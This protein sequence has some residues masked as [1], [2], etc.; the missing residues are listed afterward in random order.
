MSLPVA[1]YAFLP[2]LRRGLGADLSRVDG[3][4]GAEPRALLPI[5]V[6]FNENDAQSGGVQLAL[7][8]PGEVKALDARSVIRTW[9]RANVM[10]AEP[11]YFPLIEFDQ[12]DLPWRY[13]PARATS[14][15]RLT[16][17][18]V[19]IVLADDEIGGFSPPRGNDL[20]RVEIKDVSALP[21]W[22]QLWAWAHVQY[23][24]GTGLDAT[25]AEALLAAGSPL[26]TSRLLCARRLKP[27]T[28]YRALLVPAFQ[29]GLL[30]GLGQPVPDS[31]DAL[32]PAWTDDASSALT[33]P[34]YY[35]WRFGTGT[36]GDFESLARLLKPFEAPASVGIRDMDVSEPSPG[37]PAA[38]STPLGLQ[39]ALRALGTVDTVWTPADR[40]RWIEAL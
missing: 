13:T 12:A 23:A 35:E 19:L 25:Q 37:M 3:T 28:G 10:D 32:T 29:R 9:P 30:A 38:A 17:W 36:I 27:R 18:V 40:D 14:G 11:N 7:F 20:G 31:I 26:L 6:R 1:N 2:W 5:A 33:L 21:K 4:A 39:G 15:D 24:G 22:S 8:G 16:P 34:V